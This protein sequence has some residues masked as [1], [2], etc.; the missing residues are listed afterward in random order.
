MLRAGS[1]VLMSKRGKIGV[2]SVILVFVVY[3][4]HAA[5]KSL[6]RQF[7]WDGNSAAGDSGVLLPTTSHVQDLNLRTFS[8]QNGGGEDRMY[9]VREQ[10]ALTFPYNAQA[11]IPKHVWQTWK[12]GPD[13]ATFPGNFR[14]YQSDWANWDKNVQYSLI[15]DDQMVPF[16]EEVYG[17]V[18]L[19]VEAFKLLPTIILRADFFRYLVLYARGG[20][21]SDMD[22][23]PLKDMAE[24]PSYN[25]GKL[26]T[27]LEGAQPLN[28]KASKPAHEPSIARIND[29]GLVIGIE[30]D[31]DRPDWKD[32]FARR[33]QFCQWTIQSKP[34]HPVL[35]ELILNITATT[36]Q[37][38]D[39]SFTSITDKS[40]AE[41]Y[42]VNYR[43]KRLFDTKYDHHKL[44]NKQ[45][46]DGSDIMNWTGPGIFSDIIFNYMDNLLHHNDDVILLNNNLGHIE[47]NEDITK[48]TK[49]FYKTI[50]ESLQSANN[51]PWEFF[52]L[53]TSPVLVDDILVLPIT[54]FSPGV[55]TM[56]AKTETDEMAFVKHMFEGSWKATADQNA[57]H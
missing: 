52:S 16:L 53:I 3:R 14:L 26:Q 20:I 10:L 22:T 34:G 43:H 40:H 54:A 18:P 55:D 57:G 33:I 50:T 51:V 28:Y 12:E 19:V 17:G 31:P 8:V 32:W 56:E 38:V 21:Y 15:K 37:S 46:V 24:W 49:Q 29:A 2:L 48:S 23:F 13:S 4:F 44:K 1:A 41:D 9:S 25:E 39:G 42:N 45:N 35:R 6:T 27:M 36:L 47:K 11:P 30:A 5:N 7:Q